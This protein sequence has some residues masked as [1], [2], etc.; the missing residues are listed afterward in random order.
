MTG[1][2]GVPQN[3]P[4]PDVMFVPPALFVLNWVG[5]GSGS[6]FG[7]EKHHAELY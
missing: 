5:G 2:L 7:T 4:A 1:C 6:P 3:P